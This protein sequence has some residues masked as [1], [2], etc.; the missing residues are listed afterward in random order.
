MLPDVT[1]GSSILPLSRSEL[2]SSVVAQE[3]TGAAME[4]GEEGKCDI[5]IR[6]SSDTGKSIQNSVAPVNGTPY[7]ASL[8][9]HAKRYDHTVNLCSTLGV[10]MW[11][12]DS[13]R[14]VTSAIGSKQ[15][16]GYA[17]VPS[18]GRNILEGTETSVES[19]RTVRERYAFARKGERIE[20]VLS[21]PGGE[22]YLY[23]LAPMRPRGSTEIAGVSGT[24]IEISGDTA[25]S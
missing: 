23:I 14:K 5:P 4:A 19:K 2:G 18:L 10:I 8:S 21:G 20:S 12:V 25:R 13:N 3:L 9:S 17:G 6:G 16:L 11:S 15:M 7:H 22:R 24:M 1:D